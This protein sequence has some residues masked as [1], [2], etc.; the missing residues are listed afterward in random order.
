MRALSL[1]SAPSPKIEVSEKSA[2]CSNTRL[3]RSAVEEAYR[4]RVVDT[5]PRGGGRRS[6]SPHHHL[7]RQLHQMSSTAPQDLKSRGQSR[8]PDAR[9]RNA[10]RRHITTPYSVVREDHPRIRGEHR[11]ALACSRV[12]DG[13]PPHARG[14]RFTRAL[15]IGTSRIT[16]ACAGST[17]LHQAVY[18]STPSIFFTCFAA[19][20]DANPTDTARP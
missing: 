5:S 17:L 10:S 2:G 16:P 13:S 3:P 11:T 4:S 9:A 12:K 7:G 6:R 14:A 1:S 19:T 20:I 15:G 18:R 8:R